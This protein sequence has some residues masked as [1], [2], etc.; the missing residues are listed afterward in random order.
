MAFQ[1]S[2]NFKT[3]T[4]KKLAERGRIKDCKYISPHPWS[5][6]YCVVVLGFTPLALDNCA[7]IARRWDKIHRRGPCG[8][9]G[10]LRWFTLPGLIRT[11]TGK[12]G[13]SPLVY[14]PRE[15][16]TFA[17]GKSIKWKSEPLWLGE[18]GK[19]RSWNWSPWHPETTPFPRCPSPTLSN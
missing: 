19:F 10:W 15:N 3:A 17:F 1:S 4:N 7:R 6:I 11:L 13:W 18:E 2:R 16:S 9:H 14:T 8:G 5:A 12:Q